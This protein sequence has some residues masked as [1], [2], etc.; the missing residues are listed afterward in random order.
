VLIGHVSQT[1]K[2][3]PLHASKSLNIL[4]QPCENFSLMGK[5][6]DVTRN[7]NRTSV[8]NWVLAWKHMLES[9]SRL[10]IWNVWRTQCCTGGGSLFL[11]RLL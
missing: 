9:G 8:D 6:P 11:R 5:D 2:G 7:W 3:G 1:H 10:L 4:V